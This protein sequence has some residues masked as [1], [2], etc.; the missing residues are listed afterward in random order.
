MYPQENENAWLIGY[1]AMREDVGLVGAKGFEPAT[2]TPQIVIPEA[3]ARTLRTVAY[4]GRVPGRI[5][6]DLCT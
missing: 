4:L 5:R 2:P 6:G 1:H 3:V